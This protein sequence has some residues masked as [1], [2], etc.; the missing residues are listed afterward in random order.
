[1]KSQFEC[2]KKGTFK[3]TRISQSSVDS[4]VTDTERALVGLWMILISSCGPSQSQPSKVTHDCALGPAIVESHLRVDFERLELAAANTRE[5]A[6][7]GQA[8]PSEV[9]ALRSTP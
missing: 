8:R 6:G 3:L 5:G 7:G 1:M 9:C 2:N 4:G